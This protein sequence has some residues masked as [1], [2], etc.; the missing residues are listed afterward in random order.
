MQWARPARQLSSDR[1][2]L[3]DPGG[4][5]WRPTFRH[6]FDQ[7]RDHPPE[8]I[9]DLVLE[10]VSGK[11]DKLTGRY[12]L[13]TQRLEALVAQADRIVEQDLWTLRIRR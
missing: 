9:A 10:L 1:F 7:G 5:K 4:Q 3:N 13:A 11:A 8:R 6:L 2:L 12:I